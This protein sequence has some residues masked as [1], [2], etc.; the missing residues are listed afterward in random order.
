MSFLRITGDQAI[1]RR[2]NAGASLL[3]ETKKEEYAENTLHTHFLR[4]ESHQKIIGP[5]TKSVLGGGE[6]G[7]R[8]TPSC[9]AQRSEGN[10]N[11]KA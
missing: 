5:G 6:W 11:G 3:P 2:E 9:V 10:W 1:D 4:G 7:D 8:F